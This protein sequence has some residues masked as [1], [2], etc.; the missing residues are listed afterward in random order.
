MLKYYD[1]TKGVRA[2]ARGH[3]QEF[4]QWQRLLE[5]SSP[6][7]EDRIREAINTFVDAQLS[8]NGWTNEC[9]FCSGLIPACH[10][11]DARFHLLYHAM[12]ERYGEP[13][14]NRSR[15][16]F[17]LLMKDVMIRRSEPWLCYEVSE[18]DAATNG[19]NYFPDLSAQNA[20]AA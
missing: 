17:S 1:H 18:Q 11:T 6:G 9:W 15:V 5:Q 16:F 13:A 20:A 14:W 12:C 2:V 10:W 4:S 7:A 3:S 8:K 19:T